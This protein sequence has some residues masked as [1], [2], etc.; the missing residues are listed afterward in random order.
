MRLGSTS[1][2]VTN[3]SGGGGPLAA[4]TPTPTYALSTDSTSVVRAG[5]N[6]HCYYPA[7]C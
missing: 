2:N 7:R 5:S 6:R 3:R 4:A 1:L